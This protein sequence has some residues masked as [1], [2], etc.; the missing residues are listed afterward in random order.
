MFQIADDCSLHLTPLG[1]DMC[2]SILLCYQRHLWGRV[3]PV[4]YEEVQLE[5]ALDSV[6]S[7]SLK[8]SV[9]KCCNT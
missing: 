1:G 2:A 8:F 5:A 3:T 7:G 6:K 9:P 4:D